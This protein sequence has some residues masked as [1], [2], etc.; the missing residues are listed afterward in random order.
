MVL[1][2]HLLH[3]L[4]SFTE[5]VQMLKEN[6]DLK[7]QQVKELTAQNDE[8]RKS[9]KKAQE[10]EANNVKG[11]TD[12]LQQKQLRISQLEEQI[13]LQ[14][15]RIRELEA[16]LKR[17]REEKDKS[18]G[19]SDAQNQIETLQKEKQTMMQQMKQLEEEKN[20]HEGSVNQLLE[21][22]EQ[23]EKIIEDLKNQNEELTKRNEKIE[24]ILKE[25]D[26]S[27]DSM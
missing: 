8:L 22:A 16:E 9:L 10:Y 21:I 20:E 25:L 15:N 26:I 24:K 7:T 19:S 27:V 3:S 6:L 4:F 5:R 14:K 13:E 1:Q 12:Q 23:D 17:L 2:S 18:S 11:T